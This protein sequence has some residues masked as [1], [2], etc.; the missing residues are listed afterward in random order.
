MRLHSSS[1]VASDESRTSSSDLSIKKITPEGPQREHRQES[2]LPLFA[3]LPVEL[4]LMIWEAVIPKVMHPYSTVCQIWDLTQE[5]E[6][7]AASPRTKIYL[8]LLHCCH[9]SRD[10][11]LKYGSF[12]PLKSPK[13]DWEPAMSGSVWLEKTVEVLYLPFEP[14][15]LDRIITPP[16]QIE[17]VGDVTWEAPGFNAVRRCIVKWKEQGTVVKTVYIGDPC[18]LPMYVQNALRTKDGILMCH[19]HLE[20]SRLLRRQRIIFS[21]ALRRLQVSG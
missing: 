11:A 19:L 7:I 16:P 1:R 8:G 10:V 17:A 9:E 13:T 20:T 3:E 14:R 15:F 21:E 6:K 5:K 4:R 18:E 12:M 2:E